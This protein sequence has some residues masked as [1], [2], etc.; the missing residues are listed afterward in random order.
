LLEG[1]RRGRTSSS[2]GR[3][4]RR[5]R[6]LLGMWSSQAA[7]AQGPRV[8][9]FRC[10]CLETGFRPP[11]IALFEDNGV[12]GRD[13]NTYVW[14]RNRSGRAAL[15]TK[16][17]K[18]RRIWHPP[19]WGRRC[20]VNGHPAQRNQSG[21]AKRRRGGDLGRGHV[22]SSPASSALLSGRAHDVGRQPVGMLER[23]IH[24]RV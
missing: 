2:T 22:L 24:R 11:G 1:A 9:D 18:R 20:H 19:C 14:V 13:P 4:L 17:R 16:G 10:T 7:S 6:P 5:A 8:P 21:K 23:R 3:L 15:G 12:E